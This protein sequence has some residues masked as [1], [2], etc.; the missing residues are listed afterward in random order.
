MPGSPLTPDIAELERLLADWR[1]GP[2]RATG[3]WER[4]AEV[5]VNALPALL[6]E[7]EWLREELWIARRHGIEHEWELNED[8]YF[9][10]RVCGVPAP[11]TERSSD[12]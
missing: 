7:R 9:C 3:S 2:S 1:L 8:F 6:A 12:A 10:C 4:L 5:A 11:L